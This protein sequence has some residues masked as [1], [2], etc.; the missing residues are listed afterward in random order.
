MKLE[1]SHRRFVKKKKCLAQFFI[2][3]IMTPI[4]CNECYL[5][6]TERNNNNHDDDNK[7]FIFEFRIK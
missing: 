2:V 7:G 6:N 1:K 4:S 5:A 3:I